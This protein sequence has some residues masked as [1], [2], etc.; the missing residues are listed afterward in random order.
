[1]GKARAPGRPGPGGAPP[2]AAEER[3]QHRS[4]QET[5]AELSGAARAE[6]EWV[7]NTP[8]GMPAGAIVLHRDGDAVTLLCR[9]RLADGNLHPGASVGGFWAIPQKGKVERLSEFEL[10]IGG[11]AEWTG[12]NWRE[13][14]T[15]G[16]QGRTDLYVCRAQVSVG[17]ARVGWAYGK[18]HRDGP[19]AR[20]CYV[21][22]QDREID[23]AG[24]FE[25]LRVRPPR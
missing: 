16:R 8:G 7:G 23:V 1:M 15:A 18:A 20:H 5:Q 9:A 4:L 2:G 21:A 12:D 6:L 14:A 3:N 17:N 19:H 11:T 25:I 24:V 22:L 13:A 10:A